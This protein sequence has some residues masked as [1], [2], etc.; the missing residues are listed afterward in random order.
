MEY[1]AS[2]S[3]SSLVWGSNK[4]TNG[5]DRAAQFRLGQSL[6][7]IISASL[8]LFDINQTNK[9]TQY[10][11]FGG[12]NAFIIWRKVEQNVNSNNHCSTT[13]SKQGRDCRAGASR[14]AYCAGRRCIFH[15][16]LP[17]YDTL[18]P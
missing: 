16:P 6:N 15:P 4:E 2:E 7:Q 8:L 14:L 17:V 11:M 13:T 12:G 3:Y 5:Q 9:T 18:Q 1:F 10:S